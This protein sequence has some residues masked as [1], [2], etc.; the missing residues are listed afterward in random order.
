MASDPMSLGLG[1]HHPNATLVFLKPLEWQYGLRVGRLRK[2]S[3]GQ[4]ATQDPQPQRPE[5]G[6]EFPHIN[7]DCEAGQQPRARGDY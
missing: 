2:E 6:W 4:G 7:K 3:A 1:L 5:V